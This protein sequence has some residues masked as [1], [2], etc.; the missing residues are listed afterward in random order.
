MSTTR[1]IVLPPKRWESSQ[2]PKFDQIRHLQWFKRL[3]KRKKAIPMMEAAYANHL[4]SGKLLQDIC[5]EWA[6]DSR[7][8]R[9]FCEYRSGFSRLAEMDKQYQLNVHYILRSAFLNYQFQSA[10]RPFHKEI[11]LA[12]PA[13]GYGARAIRELWEVD[14]NLYPEGY[15]K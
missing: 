2:N 7:E 12:A 4:Q 5:T 6:I 3:E 9:D 15:L 8:F 11:E 13:F 14:G 10:A 1:T